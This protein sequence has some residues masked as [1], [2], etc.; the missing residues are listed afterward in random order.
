MIINPKNLQARCA[1]VYGHQLGLEAASDAV[2]QAVAQMREMRAEFEH[3]CEAA[4][5]AYDSEVATLRRRLMEA[6]EEIIKLRALVAF[7]E[8]QAPT[9]LN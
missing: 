6:Q 9:P 4:L 3:K 5:L 2:D 1:F 8:Y 7:G